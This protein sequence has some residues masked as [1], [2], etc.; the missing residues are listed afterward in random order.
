M[1]IR[2]T[3]LFLSTMLANQVSTIFATD[4][5]ER[6][7]L[8]QQIRVPGRQGLYVCELHVISFKLQNRAEKTDDIHALIL[9]DEA[10]KSFWWSADAVNENTTLESRISLFAQYQNP[11]LQKG[12]ITVVSALG[13][14]LIIRTS[15]ESSST[16]AGAKDFV[17]QWLRTKVL[18]ALRP[19]MVFD[20]ITQNLLPKYKRVNLALLIDREFLRDPTNDSASGPMELFKVIQ[21]RPVGEKIEVEVKGPRYSEILTIDADL[22]VKHVRK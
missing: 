8:V 15:R 14:N 21:A 1:N 10:T 13:A 2:P 6:T 12:K 4:L 16:Y 20:L 18:P 19:G 11:V 7:E 17:T 9:Y 3:L 5:I 22:A